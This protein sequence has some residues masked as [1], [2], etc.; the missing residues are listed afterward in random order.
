MI[1]ARFN[2]HSNSTF[3]IKGQIECEAQEGLCLQS[4]RAHG[5]QTK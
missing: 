4:N 5:E 2:L 1:N 3:E